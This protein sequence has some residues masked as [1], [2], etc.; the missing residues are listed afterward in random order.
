MPNGVCM[1]GA[2]R[3]E[4]LLEV[5][6]GLPHLALEVRLSSGNELLVGVISL[7]VIAALIV[8]G[9]DCDSLESLLWPPSVIFGALLRI[10]AGCLERCPLTVIGGRLPVVLDENGSD[11]LLARGVPNGD[12]KQLLRGPWL[13]VAEL[14]CQGSTVHVGPNAEMTSAS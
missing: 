1:V 14:M 6:N 2:S 11:H 12:V 7:L 4:K 3:F 5:I 10:L 13:I 9:S 8:A